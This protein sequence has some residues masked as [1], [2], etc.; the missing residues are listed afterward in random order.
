MTTPPAGTSFRANRYFP[1]IMLLIGLIAGYFIGR[2]TY[3]MAQAR[4]GNCVSSDST[5]VD[6]DVSQKECQAECP[7]CTWTQTR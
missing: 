5:L 6:S 1:W 4:L 7:T 3:S 2:A